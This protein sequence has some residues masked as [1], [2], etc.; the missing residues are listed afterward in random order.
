MIEVYK[1]N[2]RNKAA[3]KRILDSLKE[4]FADARINFDLHDC[5]RILRIDGIEKSH[6]QDIVMDLNKWGFK[7]EILN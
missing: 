2:V 5:D 6:T 4:K 3:A 1:T 7:C